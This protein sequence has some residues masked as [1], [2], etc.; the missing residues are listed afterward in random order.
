[1]VYIFDL[2]ATDSATTRYH[3]D[4]LQRWAMCLLAFRYVMEHVPGNSTH[5]G[6]LL[7]RWGS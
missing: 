5:G 7:S 4:K 6:Y 2:Y 1:M 3:A